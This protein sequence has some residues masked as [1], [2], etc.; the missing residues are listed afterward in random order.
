MTRLR[1]GRRTPTLGD[2]KRR[3]AR[4][5]QKSLRRPIVVDRR[6]E[7]PLP[8]AFIIAPFRSGTTLLRFILDSHPQIAAPPE[9]FLFGHLLAPLR[10]GATI[11]AMSSLGFDRERFAGALGDYASGFVEAYAR[12]KG[13]RLWIEKTPSYVDWLPELVEAFSDARFLLLYRHPF[14]IVRSMMERDMAETQPEIAALRRDHAS[15]FATCCAYVARQHELMLGF[16][17]RSPGLA[18]AIRYERLVADPPRELEAVCAFLG[19]LYDPRILSFA[20]ATHDLGFG[21]E[22]V[23]DTQAI[24]SRTGT[25]AGWSDEQRREAASYLRASLDA[26]GY[27]P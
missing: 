26:L 21:D 17:Q 6:G 20:R 4:I 15:A 9:T 22:K 11:R 14:D 27:E 2:L 18:H 8:G 13:K 5:V 24:V 23:N 25:Y 19:V 10:D 3:F 1:L 16:Q 7:D 12:S